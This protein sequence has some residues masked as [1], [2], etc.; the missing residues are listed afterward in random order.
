[1][2]ISFLILK[3][4]CN[5]QLENA[6]PLSKIASAFMLQSD[7]HSIVSLYG[8]LK[9]ENVMILH[10]SCNFDYHGINATIVLTLNQPQCN[11]E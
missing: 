8:S 1:M 7:L 4:N 6:S 3:F 9:R 10:I 5:F 2:H 11:T